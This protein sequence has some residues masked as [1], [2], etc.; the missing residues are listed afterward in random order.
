MGGE[1]AKGIVNTKYL[2]GTPGWIV[3]PIRLLQV[4]STH[5]PSVGNR[6]G[7]AAR[8]A[9]TKGDTQKQRFCLPDQVMGCLK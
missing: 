4:H 5:L 2:A 6:D 9:Q 1:D 7:Q 3:L 8:R